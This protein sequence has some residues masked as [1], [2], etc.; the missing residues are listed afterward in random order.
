MA[1]DNMYGI[2]MIA[3]ML[4]LIF[5]MLGGIV[6]LYGELEEKEAKRDCAKFSAYGFETQLVG[7]ECL[8]ELNNGK[9]VSVE[10]LT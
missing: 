2:L 10:Y 4:G 6:F 9:F 8:V 1:N 5:L 3:G 7:K